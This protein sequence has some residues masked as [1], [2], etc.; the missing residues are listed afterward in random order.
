MRHGMVITGVLTPVLILLSGCVP[1]GAGNDNSG[2]GPPQIGKFNGDGDVEIEVTGL[3]AT[4]TAVPD[5]GWRFVRWN[6]PNDVSLFNPHN[7]GAAMV[8]QYEVTFLPEGVPDDNGN[9]NGNDND[10][11][12][13]NE[14]ENDNGNENDNMNDNSD[15]E[16]VVEVSF[17]SINAGDTV[18]RFGQASSKM[19]DGISVITG[20][21][22]TTN[23]VPP[24]LKSVS[25]FSFFRPL[26]RT[27]ADFFR[28][29]VNDEDVLM[30]DLITA[31]SFHIQ[32]TMS[33]NRI[34]IAGGDVGANG[35]STGVPT[36]SAEIF[37]PALGTVEATA[38]MSQPRSRHTATV[39]SDGRVLV[40]GGN[41]W[42][43]FDTNTEQW[44]ADMA[45]EFER[46]SHAAALLA[47]FGGA[48]GQDRVLIVGGNGD[49]GDKIELL[50]PQANVSTTLT[51]T[52]PVALTRL[53]A[54]TLPDGRVL[55]V[56]GVNVDTGDTTNDAFLIDASADSITAA[57]SPPNRDGGLADHRAILEQDRFVIVV[58]GEQ[59]V[60]GVREVLAYYAV[61]DTQVDDWVDD[62]ATVAPHDDFIFQV[63]DIE[64]IL[65]SGGGQPE[66][67]NMAPTGASETLELSIVDG[68]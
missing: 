50:D 60:G 68:G 15:D 66:D 14:N 53:T 43:I 47:D 7:V 52:L 23:G 27:F 24:T 12:N 36:A 67:G 49:A 10:N 37:D 18:G 56:G 4:L 5:D 62:G 38:D 64:E 9:S 35:Q 58:G 2:D 41:A 54:T 28:P 13:G 65:I 33:D 20:G 26:S 44:F 55:V 19:D 42:Q 46:E 22:T 51:S 6:G 11:G 1:Q 45:M 17:I 61:F 48:A 16:P 21:V 25:A 32:A 39:L 30:F 8:D 31:R 29:S 34:L 59:N 3:V 40:A 63:Q 57:P